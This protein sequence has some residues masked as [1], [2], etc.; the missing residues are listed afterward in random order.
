MIVM[1]QTQLLFGGNARLTGKSFVWDLETEWNRCIFIMFKTSKLFLLQKGKYLTRLFCGEKAIVF[2]QCCRSQSLPSKNNTTEYTKLEGMR[3][4]P[5]IQFRAPCSTTRNPN[6]VSE[7]GVQTSCELWQLTAMPTS[8][9]NLFHAHR[10]LFLTADLTLPNASLCCSLRSCCKT[11]RT[12][13]Q[14]TV[15]M[16][17]HLL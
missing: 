2:P 6:C 15:L 12:S 3:S 10:P 14:A 4:D 7:R 16:Q 11:T 5:I 17:P 8:L 9:E 13:D 1:H